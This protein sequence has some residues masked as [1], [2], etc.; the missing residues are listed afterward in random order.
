[1]M[2]RHEVIADGALFHVPMVDILE[3]SVVQ[4][5]VYLQ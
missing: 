5:F 4:R 2:R 3:A 1:M